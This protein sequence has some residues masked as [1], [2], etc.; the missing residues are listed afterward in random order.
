[1][2]NKLLATEDLI[3]EIKQIMEQ[4]RT[5]VAKEVNKELITAYWNIGRIIVEYEQDNR[6]RAVYGKQTLKEL[7]KALTNLEKGFRFQICNL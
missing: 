1:M 6:D 4:A 7:S 5:N 2:E 3:V